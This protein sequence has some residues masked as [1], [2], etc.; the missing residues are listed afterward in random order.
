[1]TSTIGFGG[2]EF[3]VSF[4]LGSLTTGILT[5]QL[6]VSGDVWGGMFCAFVS[7][8]FLTMASRPGEFTLGDDE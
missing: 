5:L 2:E 6:A 4:L 1:M 8:S 7:G 3:E